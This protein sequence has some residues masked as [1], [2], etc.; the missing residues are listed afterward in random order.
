MAAPREVMNMLHADPRQAG[1]FRIREDFLARLYSN[2]R[3]LSCILRRSSLITFLDVPGR[4][5]DT[6]FSCNSRSV[7]AV[8]NEF[9]STLASAVD[10]G[11]LNG[12]LPY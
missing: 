9:T 1:Y 8:V 11:R 6:E 7:L 5:K 4:L 10:L 2:Q 12:L 3:G